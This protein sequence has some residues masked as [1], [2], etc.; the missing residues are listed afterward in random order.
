MALSSAFTCDLCKTA[1]ATTPLDHGLIDIAPNWMTLAIGT[2]D[3]VLPPHLDA[4]AAAADPEDGPAFEAE[5]EPFGTT[6]HVCPDCR[7][8]IAPIDDIVRARF[9]K[10]DEV[11]P[12]PP[13]VTDDRVIDLTSRK[14]K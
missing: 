1:T 7:A 6:I 3:M 12:E 4:A 10:R 8:T 14:K 9:K 2:S 5:M 11:E 13:L